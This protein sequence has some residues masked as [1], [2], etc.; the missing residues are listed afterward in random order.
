MR[1][2]SPP[3]SPKLDILP[4]S[5]KEKEKY[6]TYEKLIYALTLSVQWIS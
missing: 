5:W 4:N 2:I 6:T 1:A 3:D